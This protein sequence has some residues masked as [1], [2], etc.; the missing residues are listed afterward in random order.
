MQTLSLNGAW[1]FRRQGAEDFYPAQVPGCVHTDLQRNDLIP[2]PFW[3]SNELQLQWIEETDWEYATTFDV[4]DELLAC[5]HVE[6]VADGL[7][8]L[9]TITLNGHEVARTENM[10]VGYRFPVR[11]WLRPGDNELKIQFANPMDYIRA[12]LPI[13]TFAG[14]NDPVGG[15]S[16]IRKEQCSFGWEWGSRF[17]TCG[18]YKSSAVHGWDANRLVHANVR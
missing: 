1:Q 9:A 18:I 5:E 2:D 10:F 15:S 17:A 7:D 11:E 13:H 3:G 6:L 16:N 12:R 14:W 8:T 4:P